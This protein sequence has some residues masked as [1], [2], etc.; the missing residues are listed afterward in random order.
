MVVEEATE[1]SEKKV[2]RRRRSRTK[3]EEQPPVQEQE[4][5]KEEV[6]AEEVKT[7]AKAS[8]KLKS[9]LPPQEELSSIDEEDDDEDDELDVMALSAM[10][11]EDIGDDDDD[12]LDEEEDDDESLDEDDYPH[13]SSQNNLE[14]LPL[15]TASLPR[16][17]YLVVDRASELI[18]KPLQEFA[19]L[20]AIPEAEILQKTLPV[21][22]NHRVAK[23]FSHRREKV[24]K[25]PDGKMLQKTSQYLYDKGITRLLIRGQIYEINR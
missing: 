20:G 3:V 12:D 16:T 19:D 8:L 24:I 21:F 4:L 14:I 18:V 7:S 11:G 15:A 5:E 13:T 23:R 9:E 17:C 10:L 6:A 1:V 22:D 2:R 25:V